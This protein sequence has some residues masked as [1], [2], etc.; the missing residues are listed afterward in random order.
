MELPFDI[1]VILGAV[2]RDTLPPAKYFNKEEMSL[3][4]FRSSELR[5]LRKWTHKMPIQREQT[6]FAEH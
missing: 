4:P 6:P 1:E 2:E 5:H 3:Q